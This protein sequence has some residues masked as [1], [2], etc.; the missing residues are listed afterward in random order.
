MKTILVLRRGSET[1][2]AV[3]DIALAAARPFGAPLEFLRI[4][5]SPGQAAAFT[6]HVDFAMGAALSGALSRLQDLV[7]MTGVRP[8]PLQ[9]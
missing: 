6:P 7:R 3:F 8:S 1:D 9:L 2:E 4:W 5:I